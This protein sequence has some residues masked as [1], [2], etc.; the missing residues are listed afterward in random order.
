MGV[1]LQATEV[2][3]T[4][5]AAAVIEFTASG[6]AVRAVGCPPLARPF[7]SELPGPDFAKLTLADWVPIGIALGIAVAGLHDEL[8]TTSSGS[9]GAGNAEVPGYTGLVGAARAGARDRLRE[10]ALALGAD[11]VV[12]SEL[13]FGVRGEPCRAHAAATDYFAQAVIT[14]SAVARVD[15][16]GAFGPRPSLAVLHLDGA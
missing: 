9:W 8:V 14:G 3:A 10:S 1:A 2:P 7:T 12:V 6:T 13:A 11:G 5:L 16:R 15:R 4:S